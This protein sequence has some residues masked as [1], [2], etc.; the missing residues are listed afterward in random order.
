MKELGMARKAEADKLAY[1]TE[2]IANQAMRDRTD[3]AR[4]MANVDYQQQFSEMNNSLMDP[5][6]INRRQIN[7]ASAYGS[8]QSMG[9]AAA[10]QGASQTRFNNIAETTKALKDHQG[11]SLAGIRTSANIAAQ[12]ALTASMESSDAKLYSPLASGLGGFAEGAVTGAMDK[13]Y[14]DRQKEL[15]FKQRLRG[16]N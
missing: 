14:K 1:S 5:A 7:M 8:G 10:T 6:N 11:L 15:E 16:S 12:N 13:K 9:L 2:F 3:E 4:G